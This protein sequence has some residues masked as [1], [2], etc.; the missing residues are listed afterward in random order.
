[1]EFIAKVIG[2]Q[3]GKYISMRITIPRNL[4]ALYL[5]EPGDVIRLDLKGKVRIVKRTKRFEK[6]S[7]VIEA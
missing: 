5:L 2:N 4:V 1:M 3:A 6:I 7:R